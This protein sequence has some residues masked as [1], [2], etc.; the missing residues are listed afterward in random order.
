LAVPS[1][2]RL[3]LGNEQHISPAGIP[4]PRLDPELPIGMKQSRPWLPTLEDN[5]LLSQ[6]KVLG[7]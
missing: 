4:A 5:E 2:D 7:Y 1:Q 6:T 3:G